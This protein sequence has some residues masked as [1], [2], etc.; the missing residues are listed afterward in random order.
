MPP[1]AA[2]QPPGATPLVELGEAQKQQPTAPKF[3]QGIGVEVAVAPRSGSPILDVLQAEGWRPVKPPEVADGSG[4]G[5]E[6]KPGAPS[7]A[8][9]LKPPAKAVKGNA[10]R[11]QSV[12]RAPK[13]AARP[14][15]SR[16]H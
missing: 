10:G 7:A 3:G 13:R 2:V 1:A 14:T 11:R 5:A 9:S 12:K 15:K 6:P 8:E 4:N 16:R